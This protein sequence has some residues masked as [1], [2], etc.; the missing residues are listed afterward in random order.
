MSDRTFLTPEEYGDL[1]DVYYREQL[2]ECVDQLRGQIDDFGYV[3]TILDQHLREIQK[4]LDATND[5]TLHH[6][7]VEMRSKARF[8][9]KALNVVDM[10]LMARNDELRYLRDMEH[11]RA[12]GMD[13]HSPGVEK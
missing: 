13:R 11:C 3:K 12:Q 10:A 8:A 6:T 7:L 2:I 1:N 9:E 5:G 4:A